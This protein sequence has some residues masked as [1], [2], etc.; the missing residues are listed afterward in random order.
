MRDC[1]SRVRA[2]GVGF[3]SAA[4]L[5]EKNAVAHAAYGTWPAPSLVNGVTRLIAAWCS[6]AETATPGESY[7]A[8]NGLSQRLLSNPGGDN[9]HVAKGARSSSGWKYRFFVLSAARNATA[10]LGHLAGGS[11]ENGT[12]SLLSFFG[13]ATD[14]SHAKGHFLLSPACSVCAV[15]TTDASKSSND[16]TPG[17]AKFEL[18]TPIGALRLAAAS[19]AARDAWI[20]ALQAHINRS[21]PSAL[22]GGALSLM[23]ASTRRQVLT[24]AA[25]A[26]AEVRRY[27]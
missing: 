9:E 27:R 6:V 21:A 23:A 19:T 4:D 16:V 7:D 18:V 2:P 1:L 22:M 14:V 24:R 8:S 11:K 12:A 17:M 26:A 5:V 13:D 25:D 3:G 15:D 20:A 10:A